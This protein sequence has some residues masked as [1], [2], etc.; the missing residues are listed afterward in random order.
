[1]ALA[2]MGDV[3]YKNSIESSAEYEHCQVWLGKSY[4]AV[5]QAHH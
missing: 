2:G 5:A 4:E 3:L 1:M